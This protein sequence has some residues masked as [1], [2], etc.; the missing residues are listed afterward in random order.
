[1]NV[2]T[3]LFLSL[4]GFAFATCFT[5][6]PNNFMLM[7]SGALF[8]FR[9]TLPH[10]LGIQLGFMSLMAASVLGL[11]AVVLRMPWL[12]MVV[13]IAG[14]GWLCWL[15]FGFG[16][17][18]RGGR[19]L[20]AANTE[21]TRSRPLRFYEAALFQWANPKGLIIALS[22]SGAYLGISPAPSIR[23]LLICGVFTAIGTASATTWTVVGNLLNQLLSTGRSAR[24]LNL[25]MG[26]LLLATAVIIMMTPASA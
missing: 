9:R 26:F 11:G 7:S 17:A 20:D 1:M 5:P 18:A 13:K 2:D 16:V 21:E 4:F 23:V 24:L 3:T 8:G 22:A 19:D 25:L 10:I 15:A 12:I 6:G 14:A